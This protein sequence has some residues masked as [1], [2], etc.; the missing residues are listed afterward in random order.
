MLKDF[1]LV[2]NP[3][4]KAVIVGEEG[5]GKSTLLK[6]IYCPE[7]A[8]DYVEAEG[9]RICSGAVSY[10]H[11]ELFESIRDVYSSGEISICF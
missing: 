6:W 7:L 2:V 1:Q 10:T 9:E 4:D 11:L 3:G 5:N 8:E